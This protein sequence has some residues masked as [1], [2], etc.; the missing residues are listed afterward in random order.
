MRRSAFVSRSELRGLNN[1]RCVADFMCN[2]VWYRD[3]HVCS[4]YSLTRTYLKS[5]KNNIFLLRGSGK[6]ENEAQVRFEF[7]IHALVARVWSLAYPFPCHNRLEE[8]CEA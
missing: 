1:I 8:V 3:N 2:E 4:D 5:H 6:R 7:V